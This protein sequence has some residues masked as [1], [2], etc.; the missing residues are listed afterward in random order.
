MTTHGRATEG[1]QAVAVALTALVAS[2]DR[3]AQAVALA[4]A[5]GGSSGTTAPLVGERRPS[6]LCG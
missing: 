2:W 5:L 1:P 6:Q 4:V 3:P